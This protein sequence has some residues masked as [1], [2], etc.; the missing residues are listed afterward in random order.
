MANPITDDT[1]DSIYQQALGKISDLSYA[2]EAREVIRIVTINSLRANLIYN[3]A[4]TNE[5]IKEASDAVQPVQKTIKAGEIIVREGERV[6]AEQISILEQLGIQ[7][8]KSYPITL[9]GT[10]L[11]VLLTF[12]LVLEFLR[13]YYPHIHRDDMMMLLIGLIFIL[14]LAITRFVTVIKIGDDPELQLLTGYLP[15]VAAGSMLIA[16]LLDNRLAYFLTAIMALYVGF[17]TPGEPLNYVVT[18]FVG[19][20]VGVFGVHRLTQMS[21]LAKSGLRIAIANIV[22]ITTLTLIGGEISPFYY[23]MSVVMRLWDTVS[24]F[25]DRCAPLPESGFP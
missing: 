11:F 7:R 9:A 23:S 19:G 8:S 1:L 22:T 4:A 20:S 25:D 16:I 21:D 15:P 14:V 17:L 18:A 24:G 12:W 6:T 13:R 3:E 10:A 2:P 5:A